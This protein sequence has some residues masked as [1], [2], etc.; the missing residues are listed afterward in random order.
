MRNASRSGATRKGRRRGNS[1]CRR[2]IRGLSG[3][4]ATMGRS[5][6]TSLSHW[7]NWSR[8]PRWDTIGYMRPSALVALPFTPLIGYTRLIVILVEPRKSSLVQFR[9]RC[10]AHA[11][12]KTAAGGLR[13]QHPETTVS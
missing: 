12:T 3:G 4:T 6:F 11:A 13:G 2:R 5:V 9:T 8:G 7:R 1:C 10:A